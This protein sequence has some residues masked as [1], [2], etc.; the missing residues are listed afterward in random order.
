MPE[1]NL[2]LAE[3]EQL[4]KGC[5]AGE[6]ASQERLYN[7][8]ARK[9]MGVCLWYARN[10]EEA[11]E[12]L[13]DGFMRVFTY[14]HTYSGTGSFDGWMRRI[15]VNAALL[16]YRKKWPTIPVVEF[17][18]F[19]HDTPE[20]NSVIELL[21]AKELVNLVQMLSP[22]Y[23]IVFNLHVLE[24]LKHREIALLLG[25]S[26]GTSKSN[27]ADARAILQKVLTGKKKLAL[28]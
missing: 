21:D 9:M 1:T 26:E 27:L 11:E 17:N 13:Q 19:A 28:R 2:N 3:I 6:R 20:G 10:R 24:G 14:L 8:Y 25:I 12:I 23:R 4:I 7:L 22:V 5:I 16:K 18:P 15:M